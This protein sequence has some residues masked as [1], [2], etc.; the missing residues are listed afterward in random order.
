[1]R[2]YIK[3]IFFKLSY[4]KLLRSIAAKIFVYF[5]HLKL[6]LKDLRDN[7]SIS[8]NVKKQNYASDL[9][10]NITKEIEEIRDGK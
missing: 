8:I 4:N 3:A 9:L 10:F 2:N 5:P 7:S 1:M 6:K